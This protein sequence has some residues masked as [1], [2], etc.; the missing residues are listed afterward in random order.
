MTSLNLP[1][2]HTPSL[3]WK[4]SKKL[5]QCD[6]F[7]DVG[8]CD[9]DIAFRFETLF[10][11][12]TVIALEADPRNAAAINESIKA[13]GSNIRLFPNAAFNQTT[14]IDFYQETP[15]NSKNHGTSSIYGTENIN[16]KK[17]RIQAIKLG[18]I[19]RN[20]DKEP[21][22]IGLWMD[23]EGAAFEA[24]QGL[25]NYLQKIAIAHIEIE[26]TKVR[27]SQK[28]VFSD[29]EKLLARNGLTPIAIQTKGSESTFG[30]VLFAKNDIA[31]SFRSEINRSNP[32]IIKILQKLALTCLPLK[33]YTFLKELYIKIS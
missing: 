10:P 2:T 28:H 24:L 32:R 25:D 22:G 20:Q 33:A 7:L 4:L 14:T 29:I 6:T 26:F 31:E 13:K 8:S 3:F 5:P 17:L 27:S 9:G 21:G 18:D 19:L 15:E 16:T 11:S 1:E 23:V 12:S 30:D